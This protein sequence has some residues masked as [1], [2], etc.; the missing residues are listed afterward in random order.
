VEPVLTPSVNINE[1]IEFTPSSKFS[2]VLTGRW[3][4]RSFLDN[5]NNSEFATPSWSTVDGNVSFA[6]PHSLRLSV[7]GNN[8]LNSRKL[9]AYGYDYVWLTRDSSGGESM[10]G[11]NY[12]FPQATRNFVVMLDFSM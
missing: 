9:F 6:L 10:S 8:L 1:S 4:G 7:Q 2:A 11:T 5:T 3:V 12:F